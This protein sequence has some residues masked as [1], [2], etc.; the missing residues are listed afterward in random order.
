MKKDI[1][2]ESAAQ[3]IIKKNN[4][5]EL[6]IQNVAVEKEKKETKVNY[7]EHRINSFIG[8]NSFFE[9]TMSVPG[10][11]RIDGDFQG[12]I[13]K[14]PYVVISS[15]GRILGDI[16]VHKVIVDGLVKGDIEADEIILLSSSVIIGSLHAK[17]L[18]IEEGA[19]LHGQ[20]KMK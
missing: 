16:K 4:S 17:N 10:S 12:R 9:G 1:T 7:S 2:E 19:I 3:E 14:T 20:I 13:L 8:E 11:L 5:E 6:S 18:I 15:T